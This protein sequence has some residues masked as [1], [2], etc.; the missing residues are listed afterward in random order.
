MRTC[1]ESDGVG[2]REQPRITAIIAMAAIPS[3]HC[4]RI[5]GQVH[6]IIAINGKTISAI[7]RDID[8]AGEHGQVIVVRATIGS[9]K[10]I[11]VASRDVDLAN[12]S[13]TT[14]VGSVRIVGEQRI[15]GAGIGRTA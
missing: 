12:R 15:H 6:R 9:S 8:G 2:V 5:Y 3:G 13:A 14:Q 10:R 4:R 1:S 7:G 11:V